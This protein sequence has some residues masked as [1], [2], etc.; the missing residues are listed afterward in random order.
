MPS[1]REL[2]KRLKSA[3][4]IEQLAG[5][6][7]SASTAKYMKLSAALSAFTPYSE[8]LAGISGRADEAAEE[9]EGRC[10]MVLVSGNHGL[11]GGYHHELFAFFS[12]RVSEL[13]KVPLVIP[14]GHKA[15]EF[16]RAKKYNV[17]KSFDIPDAP[18]Y[19]DAKAVS[20]Y[21]REELMP[22][23]GADRVSIVYQRFINMLN[24]KP[25]SEEFSVRAPED[26]EGGDTLFVPDRETVTGELNGLALDS[27]IYRKLLS[28]SAAAQAATVVAMRS[29]YDNADASI[30]GLETEINRLRQA[31]VTAS[32]LE[33]ASEN[34]E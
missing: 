3:Q 24:S 15:Q 17:V 20:R 25:V 31:A 30:T 8:A 19:E 18:T 7:R 28:A 13:E 23:G 5:A 11:C 14:C 12:K 26:A 33:T 27:E 22:S 21:I 16:C 1:L 2:K 32:V 9:P 34:K 4:T 10:A 29:A 6:M